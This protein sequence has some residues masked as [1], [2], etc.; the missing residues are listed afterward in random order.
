MMKTDKP[1]RI[2]V[3]GASRGIGLAAVTALADHHHVFA[4]S[5][6]ASANSSLQ[7][8]DEGPGITYVGADLRSSESV[9]TA[10]RYIQPLDVLINNAGC[11]VFGDFSTNPF[12]D[13]EDQIQTNLIG[14]MRVIS[15][16]L[17]SMLGASS[18]MIITVNSI[19]ATTVFS[20]CAAYAASKAGLLAFTRSLRQEVRG[21][22][23]KIIDLLLG[24][25][26]T[27]IWDESMRK[28][29]SSRML[30][31]ED[32]ADVISNLVSSFAHPRLMIEELTIR[33]QQ[34]DL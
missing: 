22:G 20:G 1:L 17:P 6:N 7:H 9:E 14:S 19:A 24:A 3:T 21:Q 11:A 33:P 16:C 13:A 31:P 8:R 29:H 32:V 12:S 2:L 5:R 27:E 30:S 23:V 10:C 34:G 15:A 25:T 28:E 4:L 26:D 18:G